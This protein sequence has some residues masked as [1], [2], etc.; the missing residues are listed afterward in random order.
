MATTTID[1][2]HSWS[3]EDEGS[4]EM[5]FNDFEAGSDYR[6]HLPAEGLRRRSPRRRG[7][8]QMTAKWIVI[9]AHIN[10]P[11]LLL[12]ATTLSTTV[13]ASTSTPATGGAS[14]SAARRARSADVDAHG[15]P[16]RHWRRPDD[17]YRWRGS[18]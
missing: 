6:S 7:R 15:W 10:D 18:R 16:G 2:C 14:R 1:R 4:S 9:I 5:G 3:D 11:S 17:V 12:I 8:N 13:W